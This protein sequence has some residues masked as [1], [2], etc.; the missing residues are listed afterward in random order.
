[1]HHFRSKILLEDI[2]DYAP[3]QK[4]NPVKGYKMTMHNFKSKI[5][6]KDIY[7]YAPLQKQNLSRICK[8]MLHIKSKFLLKDVQ[9]CTTSEAKCC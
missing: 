8:T 9:L 1:M 6:L 4:H 3:F 7:N 5:L 2:Y